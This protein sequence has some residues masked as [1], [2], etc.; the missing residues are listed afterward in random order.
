MPPFLV[1]I[2]HLIFGL[3]SGRLGVASKF[4]RDT[5]R[6]E[7]FSGR[8]AIDILLLR[9]LLGSILI[10]DHKLAFFHLVH[11]NILFFFV[12]LNRAIVLQLS[13]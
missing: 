11:G 12:V 2:R 9:P 10:H 4:L 7:R 8:L 13:K 3:A 5:G 1:F 6:L